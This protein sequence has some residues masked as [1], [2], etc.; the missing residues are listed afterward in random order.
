MAS[1]PSRNGTTVANKLALKKQKEHS[2]A[3]KRSLEERNEHADAE[4]ST[5]YEQI[6]QLL[7]EA[8]KRLKRL[9]PPQEVWIAYNMKQVNPDNPGS[10]E[11]WELI[12]LC[13]YAGTV[14]LCHATDW[15][16]GDIANIRPVVECPAEV[17]VKA[18]NLIGKLRI[19]FVKMKEEFIP[20]VDDA[21][22]VL[23]SALAKF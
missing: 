8:E 2:E 4:L 1:T 11:C 20:Q 18:A 13:R 9:K 22:N 21:I 10:P 12:G 6:N 23:T 7:A 14:R 17:R 16:E 5:R 19:K 15:D 3:K